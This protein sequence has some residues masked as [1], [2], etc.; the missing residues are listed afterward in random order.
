[1]RIF[2]HLSIS[3]FTASR[4]IIFKWNI[5]L[6]QLFKPV[7]D[8]NTFVF[9]IAK[10]R[11]KRDREDSFLSASCNFF[12]FTS[13]SIIKNYYMNWVSNVSFADSIEKNDLQY[14]HYTDDKFQ[15][16]YPYFLTWPSR[17]QFPNKWCNIF[18]DFK[19]YT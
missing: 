6:I 15:A 2:I 9:Q 10:K 3:L 11:E 17:L 1:M 14:Y 18:N 19:Y 13:F 7:A 16:F 5:I 4:F 12:L 8:K